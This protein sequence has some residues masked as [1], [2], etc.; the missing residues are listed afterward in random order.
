MV[1]RQFVGFRVGA[2]AAVGA[3]NDRNAELLGGALGGDLVAHQTDVLG[4]GSDEMDIVLGENLGEARVL[5]K[6]SVARMHR[7]GAGDF[8]GG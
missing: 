1:A 5:G 2:D 3:G 7:I 4:A 8:A 6:K